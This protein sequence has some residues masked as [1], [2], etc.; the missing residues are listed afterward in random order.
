[1][2]FLVAQGVV[3]AL[4]NY[5][6]YILDGLDHIMDVQVAGCGDAA[7]IE[8]AARALLDKAAAAAAVEVW[9]RDHPLCRVERVTA[10]PGRAVSA[11]R[12]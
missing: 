6:F 7:L 3:A 8:R 11:L 9:E 12:R 10:A 5:R 2:C 1:M 4:V